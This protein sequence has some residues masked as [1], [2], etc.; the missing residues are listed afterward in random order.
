VVDSY[1]RP[2]AW[3]I[4]F[5]AALLIFFF[6][7]RRA[8]LARA[9]AWVQSTVDWLFQPAAMPETGSQPV[10]A[11]A[12]RP[13]LAAPSLAFASAAAGSSADALEPALLSTAA[14]PD[15]PAEESLPQGGAE[16][17]PIPAPI[18]AAAD[19]R[20]FIE[21]EFRLRVNLPGRV[22]PPARLPL[23]AWLIGLTSAVTGATT[24]AKASALRQN[25]AAAFVLGWLALAL[26]IFGQYNVFFNHVLRPWIWY[27]LAGAG[28]F[29]V[30][31]LLTGL[32]ELARPELPGSPSFLIKSPAMR[33]RLV[34][35][36]A[37][38]SLAMLAFLHA[39][40]ERAQ[41][42]DLLVEWAA[43]ILVYLLAFMP[44][45]SLRPYLKW[46]RKNW[47]SLLPLAAILLLGGLV[48]FYQLGAIPL[49]MENDEGIV[50]MQAV[51]VLNGSLTN[52]FQ[53]FGGY[54]TLHFFLMAIPVKIFGQTR[55]AVRL[56]TALAG[57]LSLPVVYL[58]ARRMFDH[59]IA[60]ISTLL[61]AVTHIYIQFSRVSP[62]AGS[63]DP[64]FS[65]LSFYLVYRAL[66]TRRLFDWALSGMVMG[67]ALYFYVGARAIVLVFA[68]S[69]L[70][71]TIF[72][73]RLVR[74]NW[75]GLLG[76]G[77]A[78]LVTAAPMLVWAVTKPEIFNTRINQLGI[79]NNGWLVSE[80][81]RQG[82]SALTILMEQLV[83]SLL[84]F[85][86]HFARWFYDATVP[87]LGPLTGLLLAFGL[88][89]ALP[90]R[91]GR[92]PRFILLNC[93]FWVTLIAGQVLVVDP[94]PSG[95]RTLGLLPAVCILAAVALTCL[96]Q[97][98]TA[99][100]GMPGAAKAATVL[101][102]LAL[103]GETA[104]N[105]HYYFGIWAPFELYSDANSRR[106]SLIGDYLG[107]QPPGTL[108]YIASTPDFSSQGWS[109]LQFLSGA[110]P[111]QSVDE[112]MA[113][114]LPE[115]APASHYVFIF[116]PGR[117]AE[118]SVV[119]KAFPGGKRYEQVL[120]RDFYFIAYQK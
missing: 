119:E 93:W 25:R 114:F 19:R 102:I 16:P 87:M 29:F 115:V 98:V 113:E 111:Y 91:Q 120:R 38:I 3:L 92:Q 9:P 1:N 4:V 110:T 55:F 58:L 50:G 46:L 78:Y 37:I 2:V 33:L 18:P 41:D 5:L 32:A 23:P 106:A 72:R 108:A 17:L 118:M 51:R 24:C 54:S 56:I 105:V 14:L 20:P 75:L 81:S 21:F 48:R 44:R 61:M 86:F 66:Q 31:S 84:I 15:V 8:W 42:W 35:I 39:R 79:L 77:G 10:S 117:E 67:L 82:V 89:A 70:L 112:P 109:N 85:N 80:M 63:L 88:L 74:D 40:R 96:A 6:A 59:K 57:L 27:V 68:C 22:S 101:I 71:I 65:A 12:R 76:A 107:K 83:D 94:P 28:I 100:W 90:R 103:L 99:R 49:V 47:Q 34:F 60:L 43:S 97:A 62:T 52:M 95:Y 69:M 116:P 104:W 64:L 53:T 13:G 73:W 30:M 11:T 36:A 26:G 7:A 45:I